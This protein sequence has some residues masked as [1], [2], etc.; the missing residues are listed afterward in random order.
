MASYVLSGGWRPPSDTTS[1]EPE[2]RWF[3]HSLE[4]DSDAT[5]CLQVKELLAEK[6]PGSERADFKE[7]KLTKREEVDLEP[8]WT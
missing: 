4:A 5:V 1:P 8:I 7:L 6:Y 3:T 2:W